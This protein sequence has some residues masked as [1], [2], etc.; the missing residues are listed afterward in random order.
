MACSF[1]LY[2]PANCKTNTIEYAKIKIIIR[3]MIVVT[4]SVHIFFNKIPIYIFYRVPPQLPQGFAFCNLPNISFCIERMGYPPTPTP[5]PT[6][7]PP[8]K[9]N[10]FDPA[11]EICTFFAL[12]IIFILV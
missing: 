7:P 1:G 9:D 11:E 5:T 2:N 6:P 10:L 8:D 4:T 3:E 12:N